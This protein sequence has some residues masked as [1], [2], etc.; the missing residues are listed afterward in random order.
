MAQALILLIVSLIIK[1][2]RP[3]DGRRSSLDQPRKQALDDKA[4]IDMPNARLNTFLNPRRFTLGIRIRFGEKRSAAGDTFEKI[5][6]VVECLK[7]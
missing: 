1:N 7:R 4:Y 3:G 5:R 2:W 6:K